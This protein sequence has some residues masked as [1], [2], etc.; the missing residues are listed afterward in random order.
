MGV[1]DI[2]RPQN[3]LERGDSARLRFLGAYW[4]KDY[5]LSSAAFWSGWSDS[6]ERRH[7]WLRRHEHAVDPLGAGAS[8]PLYRDLPE[9]LKR[10]LRVRIPDHHWLL[11]EI[12]KRLGFNSGGTNSK[13]ANNTALADAILDAISD[14]ASNSPVRDLGEALAGKTGSGSSQRDVWVDRRWDYGVN[15][16][17]MNPDVIPDLGPP[18]G[19]DSTWRLLEL[20]ATSDTRHKVRVPDRLGFPADG[21][22]SGV[23]AGDRLPTALT[24]AVKDESSGSPVRA[25][26]EA[27][28]GV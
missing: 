2:E 12:P 26:A 13:V 23:A 7:L 5:Q 20:R 6:D 21:T 22:D 14:E 4:S 16:H 10:I 25:L 9:A 19:D 8:D 17:N 28:A 1:L 3:R 27:L 18:E 24:T 15:L 11:V